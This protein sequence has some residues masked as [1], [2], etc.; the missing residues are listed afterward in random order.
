MKKSLKNVQNLSWILW[1]KCMRAMS[2][3]C[4]FPSAVVEFLIVLREIQDTEVTVWTGSQAGADWPQ[5]ETPFCGLD[6][7]TVAIALGPA[8]S[9]CH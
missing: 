9:L 3:F 1:Q 8:P 4:Y 6:L 5:Q 7:R 2:S